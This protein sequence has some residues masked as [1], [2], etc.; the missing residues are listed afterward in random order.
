M[1]AEHPK[2]LR[3]CRDQQHFDTLGGTGNAVVHT[4]RHGSIMSGDGLVGYPD[5]WTQDEI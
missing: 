2:I 1:T 3:I 4:P 5:I